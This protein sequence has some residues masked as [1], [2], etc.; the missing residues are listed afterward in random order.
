ML[1]V[2][3][4]ERDALIDAYL[5]LITN[6]VVRGHGGNVAQ[7]VSKTLLAFEVRTA[8]EKK[9]TDAGHSPDSGLDERVLRF[10]EDAVFTA[11]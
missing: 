10:L 11:A 3:N 1:E 5:P 9:L 6:Q 8:L 7:G 4:S 2:P